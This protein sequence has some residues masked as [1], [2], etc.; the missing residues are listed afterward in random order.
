MD[1]MEGELMKYVLAVLFIMGISPISYSA[2]AVSC[3]DVEHI[4]SDQKKKEKK[5]EG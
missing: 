2:F 4:H 5:L 3:G 1:S